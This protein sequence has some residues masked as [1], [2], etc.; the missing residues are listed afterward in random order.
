MINDGRSIYR[1]GVWVGLAEVE[2]AGFE[3]WAEGCKGGFIWTALY[4]ES[5]A[6][7]LE[8]MQKHLWN[9]GLRAIEFSRVS[10]LRNEDVLA[11]RTEI[12]FLASRADKSRQIE[13]ADTIDCFES[14]EE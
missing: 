9:L 6:Q 12:E 11:P 14:D 3:D 8:F 2:N 13:L 1:E 7:F 4:A 5:K 10:L